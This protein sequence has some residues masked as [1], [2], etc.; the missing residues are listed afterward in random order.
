MIELDVLAVTHYPIIL[1]GSL[2]LV[3]PE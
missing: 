2:M 3:S 1:P